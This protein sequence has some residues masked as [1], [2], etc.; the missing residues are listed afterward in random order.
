M[1][2][3][4]AH[5]IPNRDA[6]GFFYTIRRSP[7]EDPSRLAVLF[8]GTVM[9]IS[10]EAFELPTYQD[11]TERFAVFAEAAL[12]D[13]LDEN[14]LPDHTPSGVSALQVEC[15]SPHFQTWRDRAPASDD[16]IEAYLSTHVYW[17][18]RFAQPGWELG[19]SD[20]LRLRRPLGFIRRLV[21]LGEGKDWV[22]EDRSTNGVW[23]TPLPSF[24]R[25]KRE[26]T[27]MPPPGRATHDAAEDGNVTPSSPAEYV[28]VDEVRIADLKRA[29]TSRYDV[30]KL[31]ALCEELNQCYRAQCYHAVAAL[32]RTLLNHVPPI[33][34]LNS[35]SE[36]ANNYNG[37]KSFRECMQHLEGA[38]RKI[39]DLHLHSP[40]RK[41]EALPS[42]TQVNFAPELDLLLAE[43]VRLLGAPPPKP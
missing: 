15:F 16:E 42:R 2:F 30:R 22:A 25:Q 40:I 3:E 39:A 27:S 10:T 4:G 32:T 37:G 24:L 13:F 38:A 35:F 14:G 19:P 9:Y 43:V 11:K 29:N 5:R 8:S 6:V 23:L 41:E 33:F 21:T 1:E 26:P 18:W 20:C 17:A 7:D 36:V 31:I 34:E 28:F 12:G